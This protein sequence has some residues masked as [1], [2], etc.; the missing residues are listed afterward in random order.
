MLIFAL[1]VLA[2]EYFR[3]IVLVLI[4]DDQIAMQQQRHTQVI[5]TSVTDFETGEVKNLQSA[6]TFYLPKEPSY[7]KFYIDDIGHIHGLSKGESD[8]LFSLA[9]MIGW[10]GIVSV[11]KNRFEKSV[12]PD[13]DVKYQTFKNIIKRLVD[14]GIFVR[15][16]R[17]EL[18]AN[19][20]LFA[21]GEWCDV[22]NRRKEIKLHIEY[23]DDGRKIFSTLNDVGDS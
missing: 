17:G 18:E 1:K 13:I 12:Q 5:E 7:I 14:K 8:V 22:Y 10:D 3:C 20:Y 16:G 2:G 15:T 21:R 4:F 11:S 6:K 23:T 9:K 19:P